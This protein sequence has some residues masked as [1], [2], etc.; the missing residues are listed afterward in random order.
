MS[1]TLALFVGLLA[2][3]LG[4]GANAQTKAGSDFKVA[5]AS[6]GQADIQVLRSRILFM[7]AESIADKLAQFTKENQN[8]VAW[9]TQVPLAAGSIDQRRFDALRLFGI[10]SCDGRG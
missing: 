7:Q 5:I 8:Q 3:L 6:N 9:T 4:P 10:A 2:L 1:K